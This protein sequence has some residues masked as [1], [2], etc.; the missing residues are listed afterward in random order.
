MERLVSIVVPV[1]NETGSLESLL[2]EID[3]ALTALDRPYEVVFVDD[4]STDDTFSTLERLASGRSDVRLVKLR[5]NFGKSAALTHGFAVARGAVV[6]TMDGDRQDDP[7]EVGKLLAALDQGYDLVSGWKQSRQDPLSKTLPSRFFNW[8]VRRA[9]GL[10]LHDFNCGLK[11]YRREVLE[12]ITIYGELH[13]YIPVVA[14]QQGFK[15]TEERVSHRRRASGRSKYGWQ[16]YMRGYLD[17]LTVL[18]LGR[19]HSRPQHLFGG[20]GTLMILAGLAILAYMTVLKILGEA[21]GQRPLLLLGVLLV[22]V[23]IQLLSVGLLG[24]LIVNS[25]ARNGPELTWVERVVEP[26]RSA[27]QVTA[28]FDGLPGGMRPALGDGDVQPAPNDG[29]V[30]PAPIDD[31]ALRGGEM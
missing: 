23:G 10:S 3:E 2:A 9:T 20:M 28:G 1:F 21:I 30:S 5:R 11:A 17:L 8:T 6:V 24:E 12:S 4:G 7:A 19:Y 27:G 31:A 16:R 25:R 22:I 14:A 18:F 13:R 26:A 29:A 15:V